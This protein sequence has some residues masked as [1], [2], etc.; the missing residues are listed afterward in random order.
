MKPYLHRY[1]HVSLSRLISF[2][3]FPAPVL[4]LACSVVVITAC[5]T[6]AALI[7]PSIVQASTRESKGAW[8]GH[9][10]WCRGLPE[11][12]YTRDR[13]RAIHCVITDPEGKPISRRGPSVRLERLLDMA[14]AG[15]PTRSEWS[16]PI[17]SQAT[18][19]DGGLRVCS[20]VPPTREHLELDS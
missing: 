10:E 19:N 14:K 16:V 17:V 9:H 13:F 8:R 3:T 6:V 20:S 1:N 12:L 2:S 18:T 7:A 4:L 15:V 11:N 5:M